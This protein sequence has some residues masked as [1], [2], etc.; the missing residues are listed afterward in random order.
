MNIVC[1]KCG[2]GVAFELPSLVNHTVVICA[3]CHSG[4]KVTIEAFDVP[5]TTPSPQAAETATARQRAVVAV[6]GEATRELIR[7]LLL[8]A[9]FEVVELNSGSETLAKVS[10][11]R[12]ALVLVDVGLSDMPG[13]K[14][15]ETVRADSA[16]AG[17]KMILVAAI[18]NKDRYR[19][20]PDNLFGAN[21]YI[22]R[23]Q[24]ESDLVDKVNRLFG[25]EV[26]G[27]GATSGSSSA[28]A[29]DPAPRV[30]PREEQ[31]APTLQPRGG[32]PV[33]TVPAAGSVQQPPPSPA[34]ESVPPTP[35]S[36]HP[37]SA[38]APP[39]PPSAERPAPVATPAGRDAAAPGATAPPNAAQEA[40][41]RLARIIVSD[42][43]LYNAKKVDEGI[44]NGTFFDLLRAEIE[45]GRKLY[46]ERKGPALATAMDLF[47]QTLEQFVTTRR[48]LLKR[49][50]PAAA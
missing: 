7:D 45:E 18:H 28:P 14:V 13:F 39:A 33:P 8:A 17:V 37:A 42:I 36:V 40:A 16:N 25:D 50:R 26:P 29:V 32:G 49:N 10:D 27:A 46:E 34:R 3:A 35:S 5:V 30:T 23:H 2:A 20:P 9:G 6:Q 1:A 4:L 44:L 41:L 11:A 47:Q 48:E 24:I 22:E 21:D 38:P 31:M 12:P 43:A 19:R 15:C